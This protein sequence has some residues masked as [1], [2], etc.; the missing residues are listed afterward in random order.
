M[1]A[2][3]AP[4]SQ[5]ESARQIRPEVEEDMAR[6]DRANGENS[7]PSPGRDVPH[8]TGEAAA[9]RNREEDPPA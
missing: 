8:P 2:D 9:R 4:T 3:D 7:A 5:N 1:N 6:A